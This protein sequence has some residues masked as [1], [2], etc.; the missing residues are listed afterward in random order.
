MSRPNSN[1]PITGA[2]ADYGAVV[3]F[4]DAPLDRKG[5]LGLR[6]T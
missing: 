2:L 5:S 3:S 1:N 4:I 6:M